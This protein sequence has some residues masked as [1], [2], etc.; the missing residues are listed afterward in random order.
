MCSTTCHS[1]KSDDD[2]YVPVDDFFEEINL[3]DDVANEEKPVK[4]GKEE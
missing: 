3:S 4:K 1:E 2:I